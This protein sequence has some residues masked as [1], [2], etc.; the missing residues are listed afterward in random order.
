[1]S[2]RLRQIGTGTTAPTGTEREKELNEWID[3]AYSCN[4]SGFRMIRIHEKCEWID[5]EK[6]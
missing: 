1:V 2:Q 4:W 5:E 6:D 3:N